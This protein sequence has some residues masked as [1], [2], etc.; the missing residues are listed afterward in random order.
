MYDVCTTCLGLFRHLTF[1]HGHFITETFWHGYFLAPQTF[2]HI[3]ILS[4][5]TFWHWDFSALISVLRLFGTGAFRYGNF[6]SQRPFGTDRFRHLDFS[7]HGHFSTG[8]F[9]HRDLLAWDTTVWVHLGTGTFWHKHSN[10]DISAP[11]WCPCAEMSL[12]REVPVPKSPQAK[13]TMEMLAEMSG[14]KISLR[15]TLHRYIIV[16]RGRSETTLTRR[17]DFLSTFIRWKMSTGVGG[18]TKRTKPRFS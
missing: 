10:M 16:F 1:Q 14:A 2:W 4:P 18:Q 3:D 5:W 6:S 15:S 17:G 7:T 9:Q 8:T 11:C 13:M 12:C